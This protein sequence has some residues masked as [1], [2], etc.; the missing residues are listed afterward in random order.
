MKD[1]Y[2]LFG[3]L[4]T[5]S[6]DEI[7][8]TYRQ[9]AFTYHPDKNQGNKQAEKIFQEINEAYEILSD[10][11]SRESYD[12]EYNKVKANNSRKPL[13]V[14]IRRRVVPYVFWRGRPK[15]WRRF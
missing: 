6:A 8:K 14:R 10:N 7:K 12:H 4:P 9:L 11:K 2:K 3:I 5:S 13:V 1:Y 15:R